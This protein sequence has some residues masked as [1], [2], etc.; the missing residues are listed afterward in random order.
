[1]TLR[2]AELESVFTA[3]TKPFEQGATRV[4][5][6]RKGLTAK[7]AEVKVDADV[8][9]ALAGMDR[10][11]QAGQT[12]AK[13]PFDPKIDA[14]IAKAQA[15]IEDITRELDVLERLEPSLQVEAD[16]RKAEKNLDAAV[17]RLQALQ[18]M[19]A[20]MVVEAD[21]SRAEGALD[22]VAD[23]AAEAGSDGGQRS[24]RNL[25]TGI[26]GALAA[27][28][29]AGAVVKLADA[30]R[31]AVVEGFESGLAVEV[32]SDLLAARTGLDPVTVGRLGAAAGAA[33][34]QN[35][36]ES[37]DANMET[38]RQ[39]IDTRLLDPKSTQ[40]DAQAVIESLSGVSD[41]LGE[42]IPRV[43]RSAAQLLR[44]GLA[45]DAQQAFDIIVKG[46]QAGLNVSEDWLDTLDEYSTQ[47]RNLGL[48]APQA[49]GLM[50]Q[51][52]QAG[53]RD[54]DIAA[55]ALKEFSIR[56]RD[57]GDQGAADAF[58]E[59]GFSA[60]EMRKKVAGGG[61]SATA[62][63]DEVLDRLR[64]TED[65][66]KRNAAAV[67]LF[68]TQAEDLGEA[69]YAMDLSNAVEQLG[70]VEGAA[71][72]A[73]DTL[74]DNTAGVLASAQRNI[75]VAAD[76]IK[77]AL[78]QA[79]A[80][81]IEGFATFVSENRE[82]VVRFL[83]DIANGGLDAGRSLVEAAASGTEAF[84][85]FAAETGPA[86]IGF[87]RGIVDGLDRIGIVSDEDGKAF[88]DWADGAV[89][90]LE[91]FD[92]STETSADNM[93]R[94]LIEN[95]IDPAQAKLNEL[96]SGMLNNAALSDATN[97]LA[98]EIANVGYQADGSKAS[99]DGLD[100]T[101]LMASES[102]RELY[103]QIRGVV[104][105]MDAQV[106][107]AA[108]AGESQDQLR[109]RVANA[110]QA[111]ID[112]MTQLGL[113]GQQAEEL[114]NKY[115]L[116]PDRVDTIITADGSRA[117]REGEDVRVYLDRL[118]ATISVAADTTKAQWAINRLKNQE[119]TLGAVVARGAA[120]RQANGSVL[121]FLANGKVDAPHVAEIAPAGAWR[122]W[123]EDETGG[124]AYIPMA[125]SKRARSMDIL[126]EVARRFG[127][128]VVGRAAGGVDAPTGAAGATPVLAAL[129]PEDRALLRTVVALADRPVKVSV[130]QREFATAVRDSAKYT[131]RRG[132]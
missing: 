114:A 85:D 36:G 33:Y 63:L 44:T 11:E 46:Q 38:A 28:P 41:I 29:I 61:D 100:T 105:A 3:N 42:E 21:T 84:G 121:E 22:D 25:V 106:V 6:R 96:G 10:V 95:A 122:V 127:V 56:A 48:D 64:A 39:A 80:P 119:I 71:R 109:E 9:G 5:T 130:G 75:E 23:K 72:R 94:T 8:K 18:G 16:T 49:L 79:F 88:R 82:A 45:K 87:L 70:S 102:G 34:A 112:Q 129:T 103:R 13:K 40:R 69:L 26:V 98:G 51:A 54:T 58:E 78:A 115:G 74:G 27:I 31:G 68:G 24:G 7:P 30:V 123:A 83:L 62:A 77:G 47:F 125:L 66:V 90:D 53:A 32:R 67:A 37:L 104:E 89:E 111:F 15:K 110:R 52:V 35:W 1:M 128:T 12:L 60:S 81:Q 55:D 93:R 117:R 101:Q 4:E 113:T 86:I 43:A 120:T 92:K 97:R 124:E 19:R 76:G 132:G 107:A 57:A 108:G 99:L 126:E 2:V 14:D 20:E 116:I 65:P 91:R 131:Q 50:R 59:L 17:K 73:M 118:A